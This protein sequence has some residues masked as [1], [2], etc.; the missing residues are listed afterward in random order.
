MTSYCGLCKATWNQRLLVETFY[1][2]EIFSNK[3]NLFDM[4]ATLRHLG[5]DSINRCHLTS[6]G[7]PIVEIR[8]SYDR[9]ISTMGFPILV[10]RHLYIES[11]PRARNSPGIHMQDR[12]SMESDNNLG[13]PWVIIV[14]AP[15]TSQ[16]GTLGWSNTQVMQLW[17]V[18]P[19]S[20]RA[21]KKLSYAAI[22]SIC[23]IL[24]PDLLTMSDRIEAKPT[25]PLFA[26]DIFKL[27]VVG[28]RCV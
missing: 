6:I 28:N 22:T 3:Y 20:E 10:R 7:N 13:L 18:V 25:W 2:L 12:V 16:P 8:R 17:I 27:F 14:L 9:L 19:I 21:E 26:N 1:E 24:L 11:G 23:W 5:P 4:K 15:V